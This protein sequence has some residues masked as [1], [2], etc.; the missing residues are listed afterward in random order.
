L[1]DFLD[2]LAV[3]A[4]ETVKR[5]YYRV[6]YTRKTPPVSLRESI[7]HCAG[8]AVISE[9]KPASPSLGDIRPDVDPAK[10]AYQM[11]AGGAAGI[12]VL[13]EPTHFKGSLDNL[14]AVRKAVKLPLLMKDFIINLEQITTA[15]NIGADAI[16]LIQT[17]FDREYCETDVDQM[18]SRAHNLGLEVLL[19]SH[20]VEEFSKAVKT[21]ADI[22]G[23]N[24]R[25]LKTLSVDTGVTH[26]I[27]KACD[28]NGKTVIS[29]SGIKDYEDLRT[30]RDIG[31]KGYLIGSSIMQSGD[32]EKT[33]QELVNV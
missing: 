24:N 19:E 26:R 9:I 15:Y 6:D 27:L 11:E 3:T 20:N 13:T 7:I 10:V 30:L 31:A 8:N 2:A 14:I 25:N 4:R 23:I 18:I 28:I 32:I 22:V 33:V 21:K 17:L 5:G 12:S 29:E 1:G 16:L